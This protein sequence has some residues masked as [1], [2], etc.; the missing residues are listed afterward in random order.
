[1]EAFTSV[2][3]PA[4]PLMRADVDTD[5]I[6]PAHGGRGNLAANAFAPLRYLPDGGEDPRFVLHDDRF[7]AAPILLAGRNF[8]C[9]SSRESA[10]WSLL[11][12]GIRCVI[13][14]SFGDIFAGNCFQ[15]GVLPIVLPP[16]LLRILADEAM[17][18][19]PV[20]VDLHTCTITAPNRRVFTFDVD[21]TRRRQ[22]LEG[23]D[24]LDLGV[25]R[26]ELILEF[27]AHDRGRRPWVY[28]LPPL[29]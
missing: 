3:G 12:L 21:P 10:V 15:N 18:G 2:R 29:G 20:L 8:G 7:R 13:A 11:A 27:Q 28:D 14:E 24:D 22:L 16:D 23:L 5:L 9:G 26:R 4:A 19:A 1:M 6:A 17:S 25:R